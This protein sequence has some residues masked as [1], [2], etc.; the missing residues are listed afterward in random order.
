MSNRHYLMIEDKKC[1]RGVWRRQ[2]L[3]NN[4]Y[5]DEEFYQNLN[6]AVDDNGAIAPT[7]VNYIDL[8]YEWD[9]WLDRHPEKRGV[10]QI[11]KHRKECEDID[12]VKE[13]IFLHY[14]SSE[15][16]EQQLFE[17]SRQLFPLF[18]N[19]RGDIKSGYEMTLECY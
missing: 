11:P 10:P 12:I 17:I 16:Y 2:V 19:W 14:A 1:Q 6:I 9:R 18:C 13:N 15:S 4:D 7:K 8:L 3:G 5:F